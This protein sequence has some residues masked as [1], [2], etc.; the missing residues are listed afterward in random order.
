VVTLSAFR[1]DFPEKYGVRF[2]DGPLKGLLARSVVVLDRAGTVQYTELVDET[3][4]EPK[5]T[6]AIEAVKKLA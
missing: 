3:T 6:A 4:H 2:V 1:S 5:Y